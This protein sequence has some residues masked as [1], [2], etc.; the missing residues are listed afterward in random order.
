[1]VSRLCLSDLLASIFLCL[2]DVSTDND[3]CQTQGFAIY[4][5]SLQ[6]IF[7][8]TVLAYSSYS[9]TV[10][11]YD[12][13][14]RIPFFDLF[15]IIGTF[16]LGII[17]IVTKS[18]QFFHIYCWVEDIESW[19]LFFPF[20]GISWFINV[21]CFIIT[22]KHI[23]NVAHSLQYNINQPLQSAIVAISDQT[24]TRSQQFLFLFLFIW[25]LEIVCQITLYFKPQNYFLLVLHSTIRPSLG[26]FNSIFY[27]RVHQRFKLLWKR[28]NISSGTAPFS[29]HKT[30]QSES[31]AS[32]T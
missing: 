22:K 5:F 7:W 26:L 9:S 20:I 12:L 21:F 31:F 14:R 2:G 1:M 15:G 24:I 25:L 6:S 27:A 29:P 17:M 19:S 18:F 13:D 28:A 32:E 16:I 23:K 3:F 10:K 11:G 30:F 4:V 8:T